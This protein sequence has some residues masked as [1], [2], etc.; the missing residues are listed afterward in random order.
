MI[1]LTNLFIPDRFAAFTLWPFILI[2]PEFKNDEGL[3][4]HEE[5]HWHQTWTTCFL[6]PLLYKFSK[7]YR[8]KAE[9]EAYREQLTYGGKAEEF[10]EFL[11]TKYDLDITKEQALELLK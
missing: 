4:A 9:V 8:L 10:A 2:R 1:I 3:K 11:A 6:H 5:V 7:K